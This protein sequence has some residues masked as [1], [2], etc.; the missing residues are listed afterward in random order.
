ML[1]LKLLLQFL[2]Q[3]I[4]FVQTLTQVHVAVKLDE[5]LDEIRHAPLG[6]H[7]VAAAGTQREEEDGV[8]ASLNGALK[9]NSHVSCEVCFPRRYLSRALDRAFCRLVEAAGNGNLTAMLRQ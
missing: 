2:P 3:T 9:E 1:Y 4:Q 6:F 7:L 8:R 5:G